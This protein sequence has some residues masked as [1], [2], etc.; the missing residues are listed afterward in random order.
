MAE[1]PEEIRLALEADDRE[2]LDA[3]VE[4]AAVDDA[5]ILKELISDPSTPSVF[6]R[7]AMYAM[8]IWP[9]EGSAVVSLIEQGLP[10]FDELE[11][12]TAVSALGSVGSDAAIRVMAARRRDAA[13]DVRRHLAKALG[14]IG[15][16]AAVEQLRAIERD[17]SVDMVR[18]VVTEQLRKLGPPQR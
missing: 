4:R 6:R 11:R 10:Q 9:G 13:P 18:D 3:I 16:R 12:I 8:S 17:E 14:R 1:L 7:R 5:N 15:T 2:R